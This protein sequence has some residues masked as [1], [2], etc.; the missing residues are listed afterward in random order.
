[1]SKFLKAW[2]LAGILSLSKI[3]LADSYAPS[4]PQA[5]TS[6]EGTY[7]VRIQAAKSVEEIATPTAS[8]RLVAFPYTKYLVANMV[9]ALG[10]A[11]ILC[12]VDA[13][14]RHRISRHRWVFIHA[15][16]DVSETSA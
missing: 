11:V 6:P 5:F 7:V 4:T 3:A 1:M 2:C 13:A 9:V 15:A 8:N 12:S 14:R 16:T 10:A